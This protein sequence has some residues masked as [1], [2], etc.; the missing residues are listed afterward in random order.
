MQAIKTETTAEDIFAQFGR[1][2][3]VLEYG[4]TTIDYVEMSITARMA[5]S[6]L[7]TDDTTGRLAMIV[8]AGTPIFADADESDIAERLSPTLLVELSNAIMEISGMLGD[9]PGN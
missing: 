9:S 1:R 3:G 2:R 7:P 5:L 6:K 8:R 4:G